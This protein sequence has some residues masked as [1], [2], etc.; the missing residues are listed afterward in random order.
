MRKCPNCKKPV[1]IGARKCVHCR[2]SLAE[3]GI[4]NDPSST[5][6]GFGSHSDEPYDRAESTSFGRPSAGYNDDAVDFRAQMNQAFNENPHQTMLGLGPVTHSERGKWGEQNQGFAQTTISGMPGIT[7][8]QSRLPVGGGYRPSLNVGGQ[9]IRASQQDRTPV[10]EI[11]SPVS[12][13]KGLVAAQAD[14]GSLMSEKPTNP[15]MKAPDIAPKN[16]A[17]DALFGLPG[18][19]AAPMPSSL[20]DEEFV[21]L[22]SQLF[23]DEF[24]APPIDDADEDDDGW[25]FD[26]QPAA[27]EPKTATPVASVSQKSDVPAD[28]K[29]TSHSPEPQQASEPDDEEDEAVPVATVSAGSDQATSSLV[30]KIACVAAVVTLICIVIGIVTGAISQGGGGLMMLGAIVVALVDGAYLLMLKKLSQKIWMILF[31]L[32]TLVLLVMI[33]MTAAGQ[34]MLYALLPVA[35]QL[36]CAGILFMKN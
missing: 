30:T 15:A 20:V 10:H 1:P 6:M 31:A 12:Q 22:T 3:S 14:S 8:D 27:A 34:A 24:A 2:T 17:E 18:V 19:A 29:H 9:Q 25:D 21:D 33:L 23:G 32:S 4:M 26:V 35:A 36:A 7:F 5:R 28:T 13:Q 11:K 16:N